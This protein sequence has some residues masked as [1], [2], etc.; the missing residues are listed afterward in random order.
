MNRVRGVA[1]AIVV[2]AVLIGGC[3][4]SAPAPSHEPAESA[5]PSEP[6]AGGELDLGDI[7]W[8]YTP[9]ASQLGGPEG[10][11]TL[12]AGTLAGDEPIVDL[13]VPWR[14]ELGGAVAR[15]PAIGA[16]HGGAVV[17][18]ADDGA[19][20]EVHRVE[21]AP[22]GANEVLASLDG[23]IWDI[24]VAPDQ[25]AAYAVVVDRADPTHDLGVVRILLDG[26]GSVE[27]VLP[28]AQ[29]GA[30]DA[31]RRVAVLAFQIHLAIS[32]DGGHLVRRTCQEAGT[33]VVEVVDVATGRALEL[34]DREVL[35]VVDGVVVAR[36]CDVHG[37][38]IEAMVFATGAT[39]SADIDVS[40]P[41]V[42]VGGAPVIVAVVSD[43]RGTFTVEAV[44]PL[45]GRRRVLHRA[46]DGAEVG[47]GD[48]LF[49]QMDLP[50]GL[51]HLIQMTPIGDDGAAFRF[52]EQH[53]L[54]SIVERRAIEIP[55]PAVRH[56]P[57]FGTQG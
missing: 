55:A 50:E 8:V 5:P 31:V 44:D 23:I 10:S 13:G 57:E 35:G 3:A 52:D 9:P 33:C 53:L 38:R 28:P 43:G 45:S 11:Y 39:R 21:I 7:S 36:R 6:M 27:P 54:I 22:D 47:Y 24:V 41:V 4:S 46:P 37:C 30:A 25:R 2:L 29:V 34:P 42:E 15:E 20:S 1:W 12:Q 40:G 18:V 48:F 16:P 56:P 19:A 49:L 17:Y 32:S 14:A 26:S 51:I